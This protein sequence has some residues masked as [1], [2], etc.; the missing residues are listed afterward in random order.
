MKNKMKKLFGEINLTWK[1]VILLAIIMG[2][3]TAVVAMIPSLKYTSFHTIA[4]TF[5]VWIL[6]GIIIIMNS[7]SNK[8]S[9][10]KCF[11]FFL[12][13][14]PLVYLIQDVINHSHLFVTYYRFWVIWTVL[15]LPMGYIGYYMK[16]DKWW[17]YLILLPMIIMTA[18]SYSGYLSNFIFSYPKYILIVLFCISMMIIYPLYIF[19]NKKIKI[20]GVIISCILIIIITIYNIIKPPVY[21]TQILS[22]NEEHYFDDTYNVYLTDSKYGDVKVIYMDVIETYMVEADFKREG[23]TSMV[24]ESPEGE[25]E[26]YKIDIKRDTY[27]IKKKKN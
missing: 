21:N 7:K 27:E 15:C 10:L 22:S 11:V 3:Y 23:K 19:N 9:A 14:Q 16:K 2:I 6:F 12:I 20:V 26:E 18:F 5:E 17:G 8:D 1:K 4:V 24:I 13:S 25:K